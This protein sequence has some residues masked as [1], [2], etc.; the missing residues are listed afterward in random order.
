MTVSS[1]RPQRDFEP[2]TS[3]R[4]KYN[5]SERAVAIRCN[6]DGLKSGALPDDVNVA[7]PNIIL[8]ALRCEIRVAER[9]CATIVGL[10]VRWFTDFAVETSWQMPCSTSPKKRLKQTP[11][12]TSR[13]AKWCPQR[14]L[15]GCSLLVL[16]HQ[17]SFLL[18][19]LLVSA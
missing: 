7:F 9:E 8:V 2:G 5:C 13:N 6:S 12:T 11:N 1:W 3:H 4:G 17:L 16:K 15:L 10:P 18:S 14:P 19:R